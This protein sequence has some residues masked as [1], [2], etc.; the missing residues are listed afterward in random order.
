MELHP[1]LRT[2]GSAIK[3]WFVATLQDAAAVAA[4]WLIGLL[5]L[6]V[7]FAP[8]WAFIG[9]VCQFIPNIGP[10]IAVVGPALSTLFASNSEP[11]MHLL[12]VLMLY[13]I[14][15]VIDGI[16]LQPYLMK[17]SNRVP[18]WASILA[19]IVLGFVIPFWGV[20]LAPPLLAVIYAF[21]RP[22]QIAGGP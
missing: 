1:H 4:M 7:P 9:G 17:R 11:F 20:L 5:I 10:A 21:R 2:T 19:P 13:A 16:V 6:R 18:V 8:L 14:I 3:N 12:Y 15:A 22:K